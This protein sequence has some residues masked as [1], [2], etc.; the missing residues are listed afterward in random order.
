MAV[1]AFRADI[2]V[3]RLWRSP[4][5]RVAYPHELHGGPEAQRMIGSWLDFPGEARPY[6]A[7]GGRT[8]REVYRDAVEVS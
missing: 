5:Q 6:S 4:A 1:G 3:D 2:T 7:L 8:R